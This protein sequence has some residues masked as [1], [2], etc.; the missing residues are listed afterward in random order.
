MNR[1]VCQHGCQ[2]GCL[3]FSMNVPDNIV[4][5]KKLIPIHYGFKLNYKTMFLT[6]VSS[7]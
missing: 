7:Y 1:K 2:H 5:R 3:K 4:Y 6:V